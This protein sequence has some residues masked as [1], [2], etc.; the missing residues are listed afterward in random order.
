LLLA[1]CS[2]DEQKPTGASPDGG[3]ALDFTAFEEELR[4]F[5]EETGLE[6][7]GA[8]VVQRD[9]GVLYKG[10][11]GN[12]DEDR[13][14]LVASSSK[15]VTV[16][17]MMKL[18]DDGL[19]DIEKPI[20][21][22]VSWAGGNGDLK[23]RQFFSNSSGLPGLLA[24]ST[25]AYLTNYTCQFMPAGTL[26]DCAENILTTD[27]GADAIPPDT[28]FRYGGA[29]W[30]AA[31]GVVEAA[32]GK[33]W[34][35]LVRETFIGPCGLAHFGYTHPT[36][37]ADFSYPPDF[38]GSESN[39]SASENPNMEAGLFTD[40]DD[41]A[42][43]LSIHLGGGL[44]G[45]GDGARRVLSEDAVDAM[46]VD[47]VAAYGGTAALDAPGAEGLEGYGMGWW[48]DRKNPGV[49]VDEGVW[50]AIPWIDVNRGYAAFIALESNFANGDAVRKRT[51]P[52][53]EAALD[54]G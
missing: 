45:W 37:T 8:V 22:Y 26:R 38:Q 48:I 42:K 3:G 54:G 28:Q 15:I 34:S 53:L 39:A 51:Q 31:G 29:Q 20:S 49:F 16:G 25:S 32:S 41:Y 44:C 27:V 13:V 30:Q 18:V 7:A 6:G 35:E 52:L 47:R 17:A 46:R 11:V 5:V 36:W 19:I 40:L 14:Y 10:A 21:D 1:A 12:F 24:N 33:S 4:A 43:I 23:L 9:R 2:S 50:G